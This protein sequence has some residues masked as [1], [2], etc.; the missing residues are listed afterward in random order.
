MNQHVRGSRCDRDKFAAVTSERFPMW[1]NGQQVTANFSNHQ[2][3]ALLRRH[4][5]ADVDALEETGGIK[6]P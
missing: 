6:L 5:F 3:I 2:K 4:F 1:R